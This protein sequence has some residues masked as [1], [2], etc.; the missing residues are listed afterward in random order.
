MRRQLL[1]LDRADEQQRTAVVNPRSGNVTESL[2]PPNFQP[3]GI[4]TGR[5]SL[6]GSITPPIV[7]VQDPSGDVTH[8]DSPSALRAIQRADLTLQL[9][10]LEVEENLVALDL[11]DQQDQRDQLD[12]E[13]PQDAQRV[14]EWVRDQVNVIPHGGDAAAELQTQG[15]QNNVGTSQ[16]GRTAAGHASPPR[17][18][19]AERNPNSDGSIGS[20]AWQGPGLGQADDPQSF[21]NSGQNG[22]H[23]VLTVGSPISN[24]QAARRIGGIPKLPILTGKKRAEWLVFLTAYE[25]HTRDYC[26]SNTENLTRLQE[27]VTENAAVLLSGCLMFPDQVPGAFQRLLN[28]YGNPLKL[29]SEAYTSLY[30]LRPL[31]ENLC[32]LA[33]YVG[34]ISYTL[35]VMRLAKEADAGLGVVSIL[36][37]KFPSHVA[38]SWAKTKRVQ[39]VSLAKLHSFLD[40]KLMVALDAKM[41]VLGSSNNP[42]QRRKHPVLMIQESPPAVVVPHQDRTSV[43]N[44][45]CAQGHD[46]G[47]CPRFVHL[48][49]FKRKELCTQHRLCYR[50]LRQHRFG[51]CQ[52]RCAVEGCGQGHHQLLHEMAPKPV[53]LT[54]TL[55]ETGTF[56]P[57]VPVTIGYGDRVVKCHALLDSGS[58]ISLINR[59]TAD[60][61]AVPSPNGAVSLAFMD[62]QTQVPATRVTLR[63]QDGAGNWRPL[64]CRAVKKLEL[65]RQ[66]VTRDDLSALEVTAPVPLLS[67]VLPMVLIG[68]DNGHL[69]TTVECQRTCEDGVTAVKTPLGWMLEGA[70]NTPT[71]GI[72]LNIRGQDLETQVLQYINNDVFG[73]G[74]DEGPPC[75]VEDTLALRLLDEKTRKVGNRYECPLLWR[76]PLPCPL[77][78]ARAMAYKR[79]VVFQKKLHRDPSLSRKVSDLMEHYIGAGYARRVNAVSL[80]SPVTWYLPIFTVRNPAKPEKVRIVWDAAA[81]VDGVSLNDLLMSGPDLNE[82]LILVLLRFRQGPFAVVGDIRE[83]FHQILAREEDRAAMRFLW[84]KDGKTEE[85]EM[86]VMSFGATCSPAIAQYVKNRN[87]EEFQAESSAEYLCRRLVS[88]RL[89]PQRTHHVGQG[90]SNHKQVGGV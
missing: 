67:N 76:T 18:Q 52:A 65:P 33:Q 45:G 54:R 90:R 1:E 49:P 27:S 16:A 68:L 12:Q 46:L 25:E 59:A 26:L 87:A 41:D 85:F 50:C 14:Q 89:E 60:T 23:R 43:C 2:R 79:N 6:M 30:S 31:Q 10:E 66:T 84:G 72:V 36:E 13:H 39:G 56:F 55:K 61:L 88:Q 35:A 47:S 21:G 22:G 24:E 64:N 74:K 73:L 82:P 57:V 7:V 4:V 53:L 40:E 63:I 34:E 3:S 8:R 48:E 11:Q 77:P 29:L 15:L 17:G 28:V 62:G 81:R 80:P 32:N 58:S 51:R 37:T 38:M 19:A 83:M 5:S 70:V 86:C 69:T 42:V 75:S 44:L 20:R 9:E 78:N 71:D